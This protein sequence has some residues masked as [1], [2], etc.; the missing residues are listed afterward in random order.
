[1]EGMAQP[2]VSL[3]AL[4][5][6]VLLAAVLSFAGSA[7]VWT[8]LHYHDGDWKLVPDEGAF[9]EA[10]RKAG[11][12]TGQYMFPHMD[13]KAADKKAQQKVW[14]ER[15]AQGPV[16]VVFLGKPGRLNMGKTM[17]Q[18]VLYF[19]V[20]SFFIA[21]IASHALPHGAAYLKVFQVVGATAFVAYGSAQ[22]VDSIWFY[23]SWR[24][25]WLNVLDALI[26]A[27]LT[28]GTFG[29]LWPR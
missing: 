28:A 11:L 3:G 24:S 1:M 10:L 19:L 26:Y 2:V 23:R 18:M 22:F 8:V 7:I 29:W 5:L 17:G 15:C 16:G 14:E 4:W 6:P 13:P 21:Y 25:T 20:V 27:C 12:A 9:L